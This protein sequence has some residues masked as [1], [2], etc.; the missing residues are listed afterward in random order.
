MIDSRTI[1]DRASEVRKLSPAHDL[2]QT[3]EELG[4]DVVFS[5]RYTELLG[6]YTCRWR[7]RFIFLND[8]MDEEMT[9]MVLAHEIGHDRLHRPL[10]ANGLLQEFTLFNMKDKTE[11]EANAFAAHLL[12]DDKD[13]LDRIYAGYDVSEIARDLHVD[14]NLLLIKTQELNRIG[15]EF[16]LPFEPDSAFFRKIHC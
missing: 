6:M 13:V 4:I 7:H 1:Y 9:R 12:L 11:Y 15:N 10:A 2:L 14:I 3:A 16:R 5:D 8:R